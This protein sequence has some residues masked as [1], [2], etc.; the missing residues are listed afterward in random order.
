[1]FVFKGGIAAAVTVGAGVVA[2]M[3]DAQ[4]LDGVG[5]DFVSVSLRADGFGAK[6]GAVSAEETT[7][8]CAGPTKVASFAVIAGDAATAG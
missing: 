7:F 2:L 4:E 1:M 5:S 8:F 6:V 3:V